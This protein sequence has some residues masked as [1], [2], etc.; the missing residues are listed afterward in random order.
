MRANASQQVVGTVQRRLRADPCRRRTVARMPGF[1]QS[2]QSMELL[3]SKGYRTAGT[4]ARRDVGAAVWRRGSRRGSMVPIPPK[5]D[6]LAG[7][8]RGMGEA[9]REGEPAPQL[10]RAAPLKDGERDRRTGTEEREGTQAGDSKVE[11]RN[12]FLASAL[13]EF[14]RV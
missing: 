10:D 7:E 13:P 5:R 4:G 3:L 11:F 1:P 12:L 14:R 9:R 2:L 6:G 8:L